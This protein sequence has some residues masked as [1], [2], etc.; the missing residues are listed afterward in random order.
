MKVGHD[1]VTEQQQQKYRVMI[2]SMKKNQEP[3]EDGM[4]TPTYDKVV[5]KSLS[6]K[7]T[8]KQ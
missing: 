3:R 1:L 8:L 4:R 6:N 5:R 7:V 2:N